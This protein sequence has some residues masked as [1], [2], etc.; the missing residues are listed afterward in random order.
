MI[1]VDV[2][3]ARNGFDY[4]VQTSVDGGPWRTQYVSMPQVGQSAEQAKHN[5]EHTARI[6]IA[7]LR[8]A[9]AE[10]RATSGGYAL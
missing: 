2:H 3:K 6:F 1:H 4:E 7:G 5:A 10:V 8:F 9:G